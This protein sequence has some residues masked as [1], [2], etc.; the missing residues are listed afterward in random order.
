MAYA[1]WKV[2]ENSRPE[3]REACL[4]LDTAPSPLCFSLPPRMDDDVECRKTHMH[5]GR[6]SGSGRKRDPDGSRS[7]CQ[8]DQG[9]SSLTLSLTVYQGAGRPKLGPETFLPFVFKAT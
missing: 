9:T 2:A 7:P 4:G 5:S 6:L 1:G 8:P 3:L